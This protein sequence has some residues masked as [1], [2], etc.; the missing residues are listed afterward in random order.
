MAGIRIAVVGAGIIGCLIARE[1]AGREP[2]AAI[3]VLDREAIGGGASRRSAGLHLP[4]GATGRLRQMTRYSQDYYERLRRQRPSLPI[5]P[6]AV[7]VVSAAADDRAIRETYLGGA[8][9]PRTDHQDLSAVGIPPDARVWRVRGGHHTD[10]HSLTCALARELRSRVG[11][12]EGVGVTGIEPRAGDVVLRLS[13]GDTLTADRVVLAPGPWTADP[14]L[15]PFVAAMGIRVKKVVALHIEQSPAETD[16]VVV[17]QDEDAFL[18]PIH[19][20]GHWLYSFTRTEWD[21]DPG[22]VARG[23]SRADVEE[24][25]S[26]LHEWAPEMIRSGASGRVFCDAYSPEREPVVDVLDDAGRVVF[27]GAA[28]GCGYRLAPAIAREAADLLTGA[29][30]FHR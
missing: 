9:P 25:R 5:R 17:F 27:A 3:A 18:L 22:T 29:V 21:V 15:A 11:F 4:R 13:T 1:L 30:E 26:S 24:A 14:A 8:E 10:V 12:H 7:S 6:T 28:N 2:H 23:L 19:E 16:G 20:R